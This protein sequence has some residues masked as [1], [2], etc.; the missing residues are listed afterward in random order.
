MLI[1]V[2]SQNSQIFEQYSILLL[3]GIIPRESPIFRN[4]LYNSLTEVYEAIAK[5]GKSNER[6]YIQAS[7]TT[8]R[9]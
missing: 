5:Y 3:V 8:T 7:V 9:L 1:S 2:P 6:Y 4:K